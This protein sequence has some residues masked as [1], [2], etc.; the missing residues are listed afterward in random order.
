MNFFNDP[1][2]PLPPPPPSGTTKK[3]EH[4]HDEGNVIYLLPKLLLP[5]VMYPHSDPRTK[6][7]APEAPHISPIEWVKISISSKELEAIRDL[8]ITV[9]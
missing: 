7:S 6:L 5:W 4:T 9:I 3:H 2:L 1:P 8:P